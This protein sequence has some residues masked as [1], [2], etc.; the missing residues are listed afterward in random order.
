M[1]T[2]AKA[3]EVVRSRRLSVT[4]AMM[5]AVF[6]GS[7]LLGATLLFAVQPMAAKMLLPSYGGSAMVWNTAMLFFQSALLAGYAFAHLSPR[8]LGNKWQP[9]VQIAIVAL[10]LPL[11]PFGLPSWAVAPDSVQ[12]A[13]WLLLV[14]LVMV[15]APFTVLA[16]TSP[17]V[18]RWYAW[19]DLPRAHDPYFLFAASNAGSMLALLAY[20]FVIEP[21]A[22][23]GGQARWWTIGYLV[24]AILMATSGLFIRFVGFRPGFA[25][26]AGTTTEEPA[27]D[28]ASGENEPDIVERAG[29]A[30]PADHADPADNGD[31]DV[32]GGGAER[33]RRVTWRRRL[34]WLGLAFI[35]S[36]LMLGVTTHIST[37]IAPVPLLWVAPLAIYLLT[38]IVAFAGTEH[39]WLNPTVLFAGVLAVVVPLGLVVVPALGGTAF[40]LALDFIVLV[41]GGLACHGLLARDRPDTRRLT[42]FYLLISVG[43]ALGGLFNGLLAPV[44]FDWV[45]EYPLVI[46]ALAALPWAT[47]GNVWLAGAFGRARP[48]VSAATIAVGP[49]LIIGAILWP[50]PSLTPLVITILLWTVAIALVSQPAVTLAIALCTTAGLFVMQETLATGYKERTFFGRSWVMT[51]EGRRFYVHGTTEHG[52]QL[53]DPAQRRTPTAYHVRNGPVGDVFDTYGQRPVS[54]RVA[55]VGLGAGVLAAYGRSGQRMDFYEIDP[56]VVRIARDPRHFTYLRDCPCTVRTIVGDGR[57]R[58]AEVPDGSYGIMFLD[59][60]SSDAVPTHLLTREA[61][62][63]YVRKLRPGGILVFNLSNRNLDLV[64]MLGATARENRLAALSAF[65]QPSRDGS[66][67]RYAASST[68]VVVGRSQADL[69]P[70]RSRGSRWTAIPPGGPV[71]TDTYS[72]LFGVLRI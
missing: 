66:A 61:I 63:L 72:S 40:A 36:S 22:D 58:V 67:P 47:R 20:P 7:S 28:I 18:Q 1:V 26:P 30:G 46:A 32:T 10:P 55:V 15:G 62:Q 33:R 29:P 49:V 50:G 44:I 54:D 5:M 25:P 24:F 51:A 48:L 35:P 37:D 16:T 3:P 53:T 60:F 56:A 45:A 69:Q 23:L 13:L 59:A 6:T 71:W 31:A 8:L 39:R 57:L 17:M 64:P 68:W 12:P 34:A 4:S 2:V 19:S 9:L 43:G 27:G 41:V 42:E 11:L 14:L 70:L 52:S 21:M 38:F 65:Y